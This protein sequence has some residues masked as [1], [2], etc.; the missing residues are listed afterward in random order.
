MERVSVSDD[1]TRWVTRLTAELAN[2]GKEP[3]SMDAATAGALLRISR[4]VAH[5]T[6]R[7]NAP[8]STYVAGRHVAVR[9]AEGI[10]EAAAVAE[11]EEAVRRILSAGPPA[12][13]DPQRG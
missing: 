8:L 5:G 13:S 4:E 9:L 10:D 11:V 2:D 1:I 6:E 3:L 12:S 7:F